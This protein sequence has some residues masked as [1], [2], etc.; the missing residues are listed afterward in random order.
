MFKKQVTAEN[1]L[2]AVHAARRENLQHISTCYVDQI[3]FAAKLGISDSYLSQ[4]IGPNPRKNVS[5]TT[6]R[7][8]EQRLVLKTGAL[9]KPRG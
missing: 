5:E 8:F 7:K 3:A 6:A 1:A 4:M 9:D 2:A